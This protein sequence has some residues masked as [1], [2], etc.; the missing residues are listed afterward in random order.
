MEGPERNREQVGEHPAEPQAPTLLA[1]GTLPIYLPLDW[2]C[3][4]WR[5]VPAGMACGVGE[6][7]VNVFS[8]HLGLT[9]QKQMS[10]DSRGKGGSVRTPPVC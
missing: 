3:P 10:P 2:E 1:F 7:S 5:L 9:S 6:S 8:I 4:E